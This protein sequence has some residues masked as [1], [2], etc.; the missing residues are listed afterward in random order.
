MK[1]DT[2]SNPEASETPGG[3]QVA[4]D[5]LFGVWSPIETAPKDETWVILT[6]GETVEC[7]Y[8]GPTYF[9]YNPDWVQ[10]CH[11]SDYEPV[12]ITPTLWMPLPSPPNGGAVATNGT[13]EGAN[14][15]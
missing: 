1:E 12:G 5:A 7:G 15:E 3:E 8:Y 4:S 11:R 9:I 13:Q 2:I 14:N 10:Y 6:D